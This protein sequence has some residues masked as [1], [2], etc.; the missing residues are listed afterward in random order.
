[1]GAVWLQCFVL[2]IYWSSL[3]LLK[4]AALKK[5][6]D[7][8]KFIKDA[9]SKLL[10]QLKPIFTFPIRRKTKRYSIYSEFNIKP[11]LFGLGLCREPSKWAL[12]TGSG[13]GPN[14]AVRKRSGYYN[15]LLITTSGHQC[16]GIGQMRSCNRF[17]VI[18]SWFI[19]GRVRQI[20]TKAPGKFGTGRCNGASEAIVMKARLVYATQQ[21]DFTL[22]FCFCGILL[23]WTVCS[24]LGILDSGYNP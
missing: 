8:M 22:I 11:T 15:W 20:C 17:Y 21:W 10:L 2:W 23:D 19:C 24:S 18:T 6:P 7:F 4:E 1:M 14:W 3:T 12:P 5:T 13:T 9:F 16:T